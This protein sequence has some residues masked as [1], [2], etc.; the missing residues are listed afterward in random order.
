MPVI[1]GLTG[2][3][4]VMLVLLLLVLVIGGATSDRHDRDGER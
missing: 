1:P 2:E 4:L 3:A